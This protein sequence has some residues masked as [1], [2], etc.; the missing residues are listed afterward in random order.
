MNRVLLFL[1]NYTTLCQDYVV[2][3]DFNNEYTRVYKKPPAATPQQKEPEKIYGVI[4]REKKLVVP[5]LYKSI[6]ATSEK[7]IFIIKDNVF[8]IYYLQFE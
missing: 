8:I 2:D 1:I 7:G 3:Y 4:K 5:I 6:Y